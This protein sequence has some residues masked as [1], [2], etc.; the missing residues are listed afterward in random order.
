MVE[1]ENKLRYSL[2]GAN[3]LW[4]WMIL[5]TVNKKREKKIHPS[6]VSFLN[7]FQLLSPHVDTP[8]STVMVRCKR[9]VEISVEKNI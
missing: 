5:R 3:W 9:V 6:I 8:I 7:W 2:L 4:R 1:N